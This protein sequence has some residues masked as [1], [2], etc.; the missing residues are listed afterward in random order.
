ML[1]AVTALP[2]LEERRREATSQL[3][4]QLGRFGQGVVAG[5]HDLFEQVQPLPRYTWHVAMPLTGR[6]L[7]SSHSYHYPAQPER[8]MPLRSQEPEACVR[9]N[10]TMCTPLSK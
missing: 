3:G 9:S 5:T 10:D 8:H 6:V 7:L 4:R 1:Q 2:V